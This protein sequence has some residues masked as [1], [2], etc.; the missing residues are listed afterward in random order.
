MVEFFMLATAQSCLGGDVHDRCCARAALRLCNVRNR[1]IDTTSNSFL[2]Q[3]HPISSESEPGC[4]KL[5]FGAVLRKMEKSVSLNPQLPAS[6]YLMLLGRIGDASAHR[7]L[8]SCCPP[9]YSSVS[10]DYTNSSIRA[11]AT[12][13][14]HI[15][16]LCRR[17]RIFACFFLTCLDL[18]YKLPCC[19]P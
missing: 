15:S 1:D 17:I 2:A 10:V 3:T 12:A 13:Q 4:E 18:P 6:K 16:V 7:M 5:C 14:V 8:L 9:M 11:S 19:F